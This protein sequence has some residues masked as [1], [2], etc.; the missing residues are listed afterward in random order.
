[1]VKCRGTNNIE[2]KSCHGRDNLLTAVAGSQFFICAM[3]GVKAGEENCHG[4]LICHTER[5]KKG[6]IERRGTKLIENRKVSCQ[7]E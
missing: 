6:A 1:M 2:K 7:D 5:T 3:A 4:I